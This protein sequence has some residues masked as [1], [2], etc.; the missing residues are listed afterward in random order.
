[1]D[2]A[3]VSAAS[4]LIGRA[5]AS[6]STNHSAAMTAAQPENGD[7]VVTQLFQG[8]LVSQV[9]EILHDSM[10]YEDASICSIFLLLLRK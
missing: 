4:S 2:A 3:Q 8:E 5:G 6:S 10:S 1:M 7:D 9:G